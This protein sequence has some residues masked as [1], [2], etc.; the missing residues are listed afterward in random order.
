MI[1]SGISAAGL[2]LAQFLCLPSGPLLVNKIP[3]VHDGETRCFDYRSFLL[4]TS[5]RRCAGLEGSCHGGG[6]SLD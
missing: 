2:A 1:A 3:N 6:E 5:Q 4:P